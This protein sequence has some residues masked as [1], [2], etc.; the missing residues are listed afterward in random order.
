MKIDISGY[1]VHVTLGEPDPNVPG[2]FLGGVI[3]SNLATSEPEGTRDA[4]DLVE[5]LIL[6]HAV[7]GVDVTSR[8]YLR[9]LET[10]LEAFANHV[11]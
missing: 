5:S 3:S 8:G 11:S 7:E 10:A 6:A 9:G 2:A 4:L 1:E